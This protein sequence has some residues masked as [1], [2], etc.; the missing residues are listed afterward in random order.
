MKNAL[1]IST[2]TAAALRNDSTPTDATL[3]RDQGLSEDG[4]TYTIKVE[5]AKSN[6]ACAMNKGLLLSLVNTVTATSKQRARNQ[7]RV[8]RLEESRRTKRD[9]KRAIK[10]G[11][12]V[13]CIVSNKNGLTKGQWYNIVGSAT[14]RIK[15]IND[16]GKTLSYPKTWFSF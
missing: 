16:Y 14:G 9:I 12:A 6:K 1:W 5:P 2:A 4:K 15:V 8:E 13:E 3:K 7:R 10:E 11:H